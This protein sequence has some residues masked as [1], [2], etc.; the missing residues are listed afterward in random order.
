MFVLHAILLHVLFISLSLFSFG[1]LKNSS[2]FLDWIFLLVYENNFPLFLFLLLLLKFSFVV[3]FHLH[4]KLLLALHR[5]FKPSASIS[6]IL[7]SFTLFL[8]Q[9]LLI[10]FIV[11]HG[12][13]PWRQIVSVNKIYHL[14][15]VSLLISHHVVVSISIIIIVLL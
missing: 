12:C 7:V 8:L 9:L 11:L 6:V 4:P 10:I 15:G 2:A 1:L 5:L 3:V 14:S 13:H